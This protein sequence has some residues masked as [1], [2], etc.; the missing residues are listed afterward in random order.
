MG[1]VGPGTPVIG[2]TRRSGGAEYPDSHFCGCNGFSEGFPMRGTATA[3]CFGLGLA[4]FTGIAGAA[5]FTDDFTN[6]DAATLAAA[7]EV[8]TEGPLPSGTA[9]IGYTGENNVPAGTIRL[10]AGKRVSSPTQV[11]GQ[12]I[13]KEKHNT[14]RLDQSTPLSITFNVATLDGNDA[15]TNPDALNNSTQVVMQIESTTGARIGILLISTNNTLRIS[16]RD[17]DE[18]GAFVGT[19]TAANPHPYTKDSGYTEPE[20]GTWTFTISGSEF[21]V[22]RDGTPVLIDTVNN[23]TSLPHGIDFA[24]WTGGANVR[25]GITSQGTG[26]T[27]SIAIDQVSIDGTLIPEPAAGALSGAAG[28]LLASRRRRRS[29]A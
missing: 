13:L 6:Y 4:S 24:D 15:D 27:P 14:F 1:A 29:R 26:N 17:I 2:P 22:A 12:A 3:F 19:G 10:T 28:L 18:L 11:D 23:D 20:G 21:S 9:Y 25:F 5:V 7:Y 16:R 8:I